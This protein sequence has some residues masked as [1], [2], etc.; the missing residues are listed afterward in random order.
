MKLLTKD[1]SYN[2]GMLYVKSN[3]PYTHTCRIDLRSKEIIHGNRRPRR[4]KTDG[5]IFLKNDDLKE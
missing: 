2:N 3:T 1:M 4:W 5:K